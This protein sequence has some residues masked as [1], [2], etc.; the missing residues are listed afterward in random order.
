MG[1][2]YLHHAFGKGFS[3]LDLPVLTRAGSERVRIAAEM[4]E[5]GVNAPETSSLGRLFDGVAAICGLR[6][7]V[8][9]E[10]QAAMELEMQSATDIT[11]AYA[12]EWREGGIYTVCVDPIVR[13]VVEDLRQQVPLPEIGGKFHTTIVRLFAELC[14]QL[15]KETGLSRVVLSGGVFQNAFLLSKM[16]ESL[17]REGFS[18]F[19]HRVVP[20]NDG[21]ISLGQ[22][23]AAAAVAEGKK[24]EVDGAEK[25]EIEG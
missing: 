20:T 22:A 14:R 23:V 25:I 2:S 17:T 12:W 1:V 4:I 18:V 13:Q 15:R 3:E 6:D 24:S 8:A 11:D 7:R 19:S 10:G 9:F 21:G 16:T 5:K